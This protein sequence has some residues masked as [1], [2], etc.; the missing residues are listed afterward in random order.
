MHRIHLPLLLRLGQRLLG[1]CAH[2]ADAAAQLHGAV[3]VD[4]VPRRQ[5]LEMG[6]MVHRPLHVPAAKRAQALQRR[7]STS[8]HRLA[9]LDAQPLG[10]FFGERRH[11][12]TPVGK[13]P[14]RCPGR[15]ADAARRLAHADSL[16]AV[17]L[18]QLQSRLE[19]R[20]PQVAVVIAAG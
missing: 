16:R 5:D 19:Q 3:E 8:A 7:R 18:R 17:P 6:R 11:Q 14:E 4:L 12:C 1:Q 20:L 10:C 15:H 2:L 9:H 13:V